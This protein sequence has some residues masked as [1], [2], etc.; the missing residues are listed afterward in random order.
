MYKEQK[1]VLCTHDQKDNNEF[2]CGK[3]SAYGR[4]GGKYEKERLE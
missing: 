1:E 2:E 3:I 4:K